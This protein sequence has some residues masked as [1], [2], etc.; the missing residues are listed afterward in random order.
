MLPNGQA[1]V[2]DASRGL[3]FGR[4]HATAGTHESLLTLD[5]LALEFVRNFFADKTLRSQRS[6]P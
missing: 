6:L 2:R 5:A 3:P 1:T 4:L